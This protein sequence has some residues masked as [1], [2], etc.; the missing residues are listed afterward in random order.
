MRH[1][2]GDITVFTKASLFFAEL[3]RYITSG[4]VVVAAIVG[5]GVI[6]MVRNTVGATNPANAAP[7]TIRGDF[8]VEI[9][10]NLIHASDSPENGEQEVTLFFEPDELI[11]WSRSVDV[12]IHE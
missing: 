5:Q 7:G 9:G 1:W 2:L 4:P 3:V 11:D 6:Q 12:W 10:R 8:A